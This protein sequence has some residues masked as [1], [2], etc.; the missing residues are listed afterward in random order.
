MANANKAI[1]L[2]RVS[3]MQDYRGLE[4]RI[5]SNA[6]WVR[7][8]DS[9]ARNLQFPAF[10]GQS[11]GFVQ[12]RGSMKIERLDL[13]RGRLV[14]PV[15]VIWTAPRKGGGV[16]VVGWY[17]DATVYR[18]MWETPN[19]R[20][21]VTPGAHSRLCSWSITAS[22]KNVHLVEP[23]DRWF[24]IPTKFVS[25]SLFNYLTPDSVAAITLRK[26]LLNLVNGQQELRSA[27]AEVAA[28]ASGRLRQAC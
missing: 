17:R 15:T 2:C 16:Y 22:N 21:R 27:E 14:S 9:V 11:I 25:Q 20:R 28:P 6:A 13:R 24:E 1:L 10:K 18:D 23:D 26:R 5:H 8:R 4:E 3:W 7:K 19:D 12:F